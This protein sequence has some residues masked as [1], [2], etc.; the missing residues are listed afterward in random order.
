MHLVNDVEKTMRKEQTLAT[1][2]SHVTPT[3][4]LF[5]KLTC[6]S[7]TVFVF[8]ISFLQGPNSYTQK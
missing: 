8:E 4:C 2:N 1:R 5:L 7:D 3:L 6:Y